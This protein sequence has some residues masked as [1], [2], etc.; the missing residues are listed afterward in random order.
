M[1]TRLSILTLAAALLAAGPASADL[2]NLVSLFFSPQDLVY[3][4]EGAAPFSTHNIY[5]LL[6]GPTMATLAG[7]EAGYDFTGEGR[8]LSLE[9][10]DPAAVNAGTD[11]NLLVTLAE[12]LPC[13]WITVLARISFLYMD[14]T[15]G[16]ILFTI[17][18]ATP[19]SR[20]PLRPVLRPTDGD[21]VAA[22]LLWLPGEPCAAINNYLWSSE[23]CTIPTESWSWDGVKSLYR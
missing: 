4:R 19:G 8:V 21:P 12:P 10:P 22:Q 20:D 5:I 6:V 23:H 7:Y 1:K 2:T 16:G 13:A 17:H 14:T 9:L 18:G 15:G 3:C 11:Q